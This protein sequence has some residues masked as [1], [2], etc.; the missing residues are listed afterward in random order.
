MEMAEYESEGI[1]AET[2]TFTDNQSF[3]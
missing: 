3:L 2:L 1:M